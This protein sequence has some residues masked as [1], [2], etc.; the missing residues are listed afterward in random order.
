MTQLAIVL[1]KL[2]LYVF[3]RKLGGILK[4]FNSYLPHKT[5]N[6]L[7]T[8]ST[9]ALHFT[10]SELQRRLLLVLVINKATSVASFNLLIAYNFRFTELF[11]VNFLLFVPVNSNIPLK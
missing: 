6:H 3:S 1:T 11:T 9:G 8:P 7:S 4:Y 5:E 10:I 2:I